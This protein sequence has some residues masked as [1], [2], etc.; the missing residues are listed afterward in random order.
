MVHLGSH[1][2]IFQETISAVQRLLNNSMCTLPCTNIITFKFV[3]ALSNSCVK[4]TECLP[5]YKFTVVTLCLLVGNELLPA[6]DSGG[7]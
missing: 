5:C 2:I 7:E 3:I 6:T 4:T 1:A